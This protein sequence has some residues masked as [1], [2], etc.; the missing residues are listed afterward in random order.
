MKFHF[1]KYKTLKKYKVVELPWVLQYITLRLFLDTFFSALGLPRAMW[2]GIACMSVCLPFTEDCT[3]RAQD[4][5]LFNVVG[6][7][8][9]IVL[10]LVLPESMYSLMGIIG[11]IGVG[12]SAGYRWQTAFNTLTGYV[13][14]ILYI[15]NSVILC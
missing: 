14:G 5:G 11:G 1:K 2:A 10:Y 8:L 4:R 13:S 12:Y 15:K 9:F 3:G 6:A 7:A